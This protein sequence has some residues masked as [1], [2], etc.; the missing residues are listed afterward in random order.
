LGSLKNDDSVGT[1]KKDES[2]PGSTMTINWEES[3]QSAAQE[4]NTVSSPKP[5]DP[6]VKKTVD[7]STTTKSGKKLPKWLQEKK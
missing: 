2:K 6:E 5:K 3:D 7:N 1:Y 4:E